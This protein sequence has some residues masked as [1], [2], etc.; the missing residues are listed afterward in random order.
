[1]LRLSRRQKERWKRAKHIFVVL[2]FFVRIR[3]EHLQFLETQPTFRTDFRDTTGGAVHMVH[4]ACI[5]TDTRVHP[6]PL[7]DYLPFELVH[8][9]IWIWFWANRCRSL[10]R[11]THSGTQW[12]QRA[13]HSDTRPAQGTKKLITEYLQLMNIC[14]LWMICWARRCM[15]DN[16]AALSALALLRSS[17]PQK[18]QGDQNPWLQRIWDNA[19]L[20]VHTATVCSMS[21]QCQALNFGEGCVRMNI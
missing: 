11:C 19:D 17:L 18:G 12:G 2:P 5:E 6:A 10:G 15:D 1:M 8:A 20:Y 4:I 14:R 21:A 9:G 3:V 7:A 16:R 13:R